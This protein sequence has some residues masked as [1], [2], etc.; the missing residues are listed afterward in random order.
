V[1]PD[2]GYYARAF[3]EILDVSA[4]EKA[5]AQPG[6]ESYHKDFHARVSA[7]D[8]LQ[9]S[10]MHLIENLARAPVLVLAC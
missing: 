8:R 2:R 7:D 5:A 6:K 10:V 9:G 4:Q 3:G 1:T